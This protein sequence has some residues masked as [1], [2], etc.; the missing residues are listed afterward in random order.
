M[1]L[2]GYTGYTKEAKKEHVSEIRQD[3]QERYIKIKNGICPR[4]GGTLIKRKGK[5]GSFLGCSNY[6]KCRFTENL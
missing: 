5:Y 6:P 3:T 4:C 1:K 2:S